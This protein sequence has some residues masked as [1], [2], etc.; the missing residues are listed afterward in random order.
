MSL[1]NRPVFL[2][3]A[4]IP[5]LIRLIEESPDLVGDLQI[6]GAIRSIRGKEALDALPKSYDGM[7]SELRRLIQRLTKRRQVKLRRIHVDGPRD[8]LAVDLESR[9]RIHLT[10]N[11]EVWI[12]R[13]VVTGEMIVEL[14]GA[15]IQRERYSDIGEGGSLPTRSLDR[16]SAGLKK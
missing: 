16:S 2:A 4:S 5:A 11:R 1:R 9:H 13:R 10:F 8:E 14:D 7:T 15:E 12:A 6:R 3:A